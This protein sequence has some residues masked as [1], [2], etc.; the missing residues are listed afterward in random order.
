VAGRASG[1]AGYMT[2]KN[3]NSY[4]VNKK[5]FR[6]NGGLEEY[7]L[8]LVRSVLDVGIS[9]TARIFDTTNKT[10]RKW[11][12]KFKDVQTLSRQE[13]L[14]SLRNKSRLGQY[15][16]KKLSDDITD[17]IVELRKGNSWGAFFIHNILKPPCCE[18]TVHNKLVRAGLVGKQKTKTQK[19]A[20]M[21]ELRNEM[22]VF[23]KL[24]N[25]LKYLSDIAN[26]Y[27]AIILKKIPKYLLTNRDY[28]SGFTFI[29]F[30][31]TKES[32]GPAILS[33]FA[34]DLLEEA[35][36]DLSGSHSQSDN[37]TEYRGLGKKHGLSAYEE[38]NTNR[39]MVCYY[40]PPRSPTSNSDAE[41][42]HNR[43]EVEFFDVESILNEDDLLYKSWLYMMWYN[44][45]RPNRNKGRKS[46]IEILRE[47]GYT[48]IDR[49]ATYQPI[50]VDDYVKDFELIKKGGYFK[51]ASPKYQLKTT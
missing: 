19:R 42:F 43:I 24:Q 18:R 29:A 38:T 6:K 21:T 5:E 25:D 49:L 36:V 3:G 11:F 14:D 28:K 17:K 23:Q 16:P 33:A 1:K 22:K 48:N 10:V 41:S 27:P 39:G 35:G 32:H 34:A 44:G 4:M 30:S 7:R 37:G 13:Q 47:N 2:P 12:Y 51:Y 15:H 46:P 26:I 20:D 8:R 9:E 50:I 45:Y 31:Y 40:I